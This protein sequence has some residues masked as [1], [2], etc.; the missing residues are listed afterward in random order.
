MSLPATATDPTEAARWQ[1][2]EQNYM[3]SSRRSTLHARITLAILV[4]GAAIWL[5][6]Q[7]LSM[8]V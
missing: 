8:P 5:G 2:W 6:L 7:L 1:A 3:A 4:T